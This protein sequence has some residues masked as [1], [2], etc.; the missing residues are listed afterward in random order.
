MFFLI[1]RVTPFANAK[2]R[3]DNYRNRN[4]ANKKTKYNKNEA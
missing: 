3:S 1:K 4:K 2:V